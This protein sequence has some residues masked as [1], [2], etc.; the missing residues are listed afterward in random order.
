MACIGWQQQLCGDARP[1]TPTLGEFLH[2]V[3]GQQRFFAMDLLRHAALLRALVKRDFTA[4]YKGSFAGFAWSL[5]VPLTMLALYTL[6]FRVA[7]QV[8]WPTNGDVSNADFAAILFSGMIVFNFFAE[9]LNRAP[10][11]VTSNPNYVK[12]V[13]FPLEILPWVSV[14][15]ALIHFAISFAILM[16]FLLFTGVYPGA[17]ALLVP[18]I[19]IPLILKVAGLAWIFASLGVYFRDLA[20]GV[21]IIANG[22][23]FLAPIFYP[24][25][26]LPAAFQGLISWNPITLPIL[27]VR[28]VLMWGNMISWTD[29]GLSLIAGLLMAQIGFWWFQKTKDG[30]ADV[31]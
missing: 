16:G 14:F 13:V 7:F 8:R 2:T 17:G 21:S 3:T 24:T 30:F 18:V 19:M 4:R 31:L 27:Q 5:I 1:S 20:Q 28:D 25:E 10:I 15:S 11:L 12:K 6:V 9:V 26:N 22:A 29:W 23:L